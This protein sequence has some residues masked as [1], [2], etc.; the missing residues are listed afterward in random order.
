VL[1]TLVGGVG[2]YVHRRA[3]TTFGLET[4]GRRG[5]GVVLVAGLLSLLAA[6]LTGRWVPGVSDG[7]LEVFALVGSV[8]VLGALLSTAFLLPLDL[9]RGVFAG[10]SKLRRAK[11]SADEAPLP[12]DEAPADALPR[13]AA[14]PLASGRREF[15]GRTAAGAAL[16][17]GPSVSLYG[18][19]FGR[20]DYAL[21]EVPVRIPGLSPRL[22]GYSIVQLSDIHFGTFIGE[23]ELRAAE[24][25]VRRAR[26]DL[27]VL[28]GD[29]VDHEAHYATMVG[30]LV[31]RLAPLARDGVAMCPGNHDYYTGVEHVIDAVVRGG[32]RVLRNAG[33]VIG[34]RDG[35]ALLGVDD[36]WASRDGIHPGADID[37]AIAMVPSDLP[38]VLLCHNP[39][40]FH[41]VAAQTQLVLS[42]HT[43]GGQVR[44]G[45]NPAGWV[46]PYGYVAGAY[47][48]D[49][50]TLYV[51]RGFGTAGPPIRVGS[52]PEVTKHVLLAG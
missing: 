3:A 40:Y 18:G 50:S 30:R 32:G 2:V 36:L 7:T 15:L 47:R 46:L 12:E 20:H 27:I 11:R 42:G 28:T 35:F 31:R 45:V 9:L 19:V 22:D 21:E 49:G 5:L 38:R 33:E 24:E 43:H 23:P 41:E 37:T 8:V 48:K 44:F 29:L 13:L 1:L 39:A 51:N 10:A 4:R 16:L 26:P 25:M 6:R 14:P 52:A 17:L 34:G